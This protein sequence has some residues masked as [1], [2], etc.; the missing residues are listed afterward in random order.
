[1]CFPASSKWLCS[2]VFLLAF[3]SISHGQAVDPF[4]KPNAENPIGEP[5][6][7]VRYQQAAEEEQPDRLETAVS[8]FT[9]GNHTLD[10]VAVVHLGDKAYFEKLSSNLES[11][12]HVLYELVG[13]PY[14]E[15]TRRL[16][17]QQSEDS[18]LAQ[19]QEIQQMAKDLL[20]LDFQIDE[21]DYL[22]PNFL[23]ADMTAEEFA[24]HSGGNQSLSNTFARA[25]KLA[26]SGHMRGVP[27]SEA[28][29]NQF[30]MAMMGAVMSG[31]S[32]QLKRSLGPILAEAEVFI[33]KM[34][35][36]EESVLIS[37]RN[38]IVMAKIEEVAGLS[39]AQPQRDAVF[40]GAGHMPDIETRLL[41]M[42]YTK[43]ETLWLP[44]WT[45]GAGNERNENAPT[46]PELMSKAASLMKM[47]QSNAEGE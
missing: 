24:H 16:A 18:D 32:N 7:Y 45:I 29:S 25:M 2:A 21:I 38:E 22:S 4:A 6:D 14:T 27:T 30:M 17:H 37:K 36:D 5:A 26:Q 8:R 31:N 35:E 1:M 12:D 33:S 44:A 3:V 13:G 47:M 40:Y 41:E 34:E 15:E 11:Y 9:K 10:L 42:G 43:G 28:E 23:H 19:V 39:A 46:L 20:G